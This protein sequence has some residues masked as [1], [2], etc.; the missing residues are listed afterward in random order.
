MFNQYWYPSEEPP[1]ILELEA[2]MQALP[3][4][5][6]QEFFEMSGR[7]RSILEADGG[8]ADPHT[9]LLNNFLHDRLMFRQLNAQ[10]QLIP[11]VMSDARFL[12]LQFQRTD[13][14]GSVVPTLQNQYL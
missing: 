9:Q 13:M 5:E 4:P 14:P 12:F 3:L 8:W 6:N 7:I 10:F 11:T 2:D 1:W